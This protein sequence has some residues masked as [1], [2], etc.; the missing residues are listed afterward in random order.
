MNRDRLDKEVFTEL[1]G[2]YLFEMDTFIS[3]CVSKFLVRF[4]SPVTQ[5]S[6]YQISKVISKLQSK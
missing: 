1:N 3:N 4:K 6:K 5:K 2:Q